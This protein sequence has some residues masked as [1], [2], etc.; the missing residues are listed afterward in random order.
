MKSFC[1]GSILETRYPEVNGE[2]LVRRNDIE[3]MV[4]WIDELKTFLD[5]LKP[6]SPCWARM[7]TELKLLLAQWKWSCLSSKVI[8]MSMNDGSR[9][10]MPC[11][12]AFSMNVSNRRGGMPTSSPEAAESGS[13]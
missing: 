5:V 13:S 12:K 10:E 4:V 2:N 7:L 3:G 6:Y 9:C 1:Q 11:L 8:L